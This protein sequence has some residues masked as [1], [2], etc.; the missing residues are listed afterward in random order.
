MLLYTKNIED[1]NI[2]ISKLQFY[3]YAKIFMQYSVLYK[4]IYTVY[5]VYIKKEINLSIVIFL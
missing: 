5:T 4:Y 1:K 2:K 3:I